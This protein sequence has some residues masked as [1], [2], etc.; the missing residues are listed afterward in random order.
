M[1]GEVNLTVVREAIP[2]VESLCTAVRTGDGGLKEVAA[3]KVM[4]QEGRGDALSTSGIGRAPHCRVR[5]IAGLDRPAL[6]DQRSDDGKR[7]SRHPS[8]I[9]RLVRPETSP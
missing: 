6:D 1:E 2:V 5:G 7:G 4:E 8:M 3:K 9:A